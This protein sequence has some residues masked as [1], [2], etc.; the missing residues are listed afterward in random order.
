VT[1]SAAASYAPLLRRISALAL[2]FSVEVLVFSIWLDNAALAGAHGL[3]GGL[4]LWGA[5]AVRAAVGFT[6]LF[7]ACSFLK[8]RPLLAGISTELASVALRW[9]LLG[10]H[11]AAM[12]LFAALSHVLYASTGTGALQADTLVSAWLAVGLAAIA[13]A[14]AAFIPPATWTRLFRGTGRLGLGVLVAVA[15]ACVLGNVV[16]SLWVSTAH[17]TMTLVYFILHPFLPGLWADPTRLLIGTARF[18]VEIAPQC[19]GLEGIA[20]ILAFTS[21]WLVVFHKE[22][23]FPNALA[24]L[25]AGVVLMFAANILRIAALIALGDAGAQRIALGGFHSQAGWIAFNLVAVGF[26]LGARRIPWLA[27]PAHRN[28]REHIPFRENTAAA[29]LMPLIVVL[30]TDMT[31]TAVSSGFDWFYA[32]RFVAAAGVLWFFRK[33]YAGLGWRCT[34][35]APVAGVLVFLLWIGLGHWSHAVSDTMPAALSAAPELQRRLWIAGRV[36]G[37]V[38]AAPLVEEL[39]FRGYLLR[40]LI[41][42]GFESVSLR[43]FTW[44]ALIV[45]SLLF[46][47]L[48]GDRWFAGTLAGL[49]Y[50]AASLRRGRIADAVVAHATTNAMLAGYV[51]L[52]GKWHFW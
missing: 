7:A 8:H 24:L 34:W 15:A 2:L 6:G 38:V 46:G 40:R 49:V 39:A 37:A 9:G 32:L 4:Y 11:I 21:L 13:L 23:R 50:S 44:P 31:T 16:R 26:A 43:R 29:Y 52:W 12:L 47:F 1:N 36:L 51:L 14:M 48:H 3:A 25:P 20:L 5:W 42:D 41:S 17:V 35:F 22:F 19:S 18:S 10:L 27:G 28:L 33:H 30:A 45:S